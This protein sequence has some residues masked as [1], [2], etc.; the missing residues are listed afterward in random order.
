[1]QA[2]VWIVEDSWKATVA[3]AAQL[4]PADADITLLYVRAAEAESVARGALHGLL[5]RRNP[6][7]GQSVA[8]LSEQGAHEL[9]S[10]AQQQLGRQSTVEARSGRAEQEVLAAAE[11]MDVLLMAR[12]GD[13]AHRGPRSLGPSGRFVVEHAQCAVLL[14]WPG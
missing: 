7:A 8:S 11:G 4:L 12:D 13:R 10:D 2:L 9:L 6:T 14:V 1:M 5:G 3:A